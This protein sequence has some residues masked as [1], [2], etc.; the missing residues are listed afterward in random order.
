MSWA[1][2]SARPS[3]AFAALPK[4]AA[5]C[6]AGSAAHAGNASRAASI[7]ARASSASEDGYTPVTSD[8]RQGFR[9]S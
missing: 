1:I 3:S 8:G 2:C 5:R 4:Y 6:A 7:A 9:F